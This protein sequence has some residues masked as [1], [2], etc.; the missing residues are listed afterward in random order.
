MK[1]PRELARL[2]P[3]VYKILGKYWLEAF[4]QGVSCLLTL[5]IF[6]TLLSFLE[7]TFS[8][9]VIIFI[10]L[11]L[12]AAIGYYLYHKRPKKEEI[13]LLIDKKL[14]SKERLLTYFEFNGEGKSPNPLFNHLKREV[15]DYFRKTPLKLTLEKRKIIINSAIALGLTLLLIFLPLLGE[16]VEKNSFFQGIKEEKLEEIQEDIDYLKDL[17]EEF[18]ND[19]IEELELIKKLMEKGKSM[20]E[21]ELL[22]REWQ[23]L[24]LEK[25]EEIKEVLETIE[26]LEDLL[27]FPDPSLNSEEIKE[28]LEKLKDL[29]LK[30]DVKEKIEEFLEGIKEGSLQQG[31]WESL[32]ELLKEIGQD[33]SLTPIEDL[34]G[35]LHGNDGDDSDDSSDNDGS[36]DGSGNDNGGGDNGDGTGDCHSP[37]GEDGQREQEFTFI[38]KDAQLKLEGTGEDGYTLE[39]ILKLNPEITNVPYSDIYREYYIQGLT[40]IKKGEIPKPLEDYIRQY[41]KAIAP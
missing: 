34:L 22:I 36:N 28:M 19:L 33:I 39:E 8:K 18:Y 41:F 6:F 23:E 40:S 24:L 4:L 13:A 26:K 9:N 14:G 5:N 29:P 35:D 10:N 15:E 32:G 12:T 30:G 11:L 7:I 21:L 31:D 37:I 2:K 17:D 25:R 16:G 20:E 1:W 3:L 27:N 38:P